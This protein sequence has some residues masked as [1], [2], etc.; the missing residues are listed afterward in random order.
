MPK[1]SQIRSLHDVVTRFRENWV[2]YAREYRVLLILTILA[3]LA[4]A[5]S[6]IYFMLHRGPGPEQH[7]MVRTVSYLLGPILG[8]LIGKS[9]QF[10]AL[11]GLTVFLRRWARYIFLAVIVIYTWAAWYNFWGHH[12]YYPRLLQILDHVTV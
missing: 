6:T 2:G 3:T 9:V 5:A 11:I 8:P 10:F 12:Y 4:D 1:M 7:P